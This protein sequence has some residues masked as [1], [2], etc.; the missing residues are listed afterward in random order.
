M[1]RLFAILVCYV[2]LAA[3]LTQ[4]TQM[5]ATFN[6]LARRSRMTDDALRR[7]LARLS[8]AVGG[9]PLVESKGRRLVLTAL[10]HEL[11]LIAQ[12][13]IAVTQGGQ[14]ETE[15]V[16]SLKI[17]VAVGIDPRLLA[18]AAVRFLEVYQEMLALQFETLD[19]QTISEGIR[20]GTVA[21]AVVWEGDQLTPGGKRLEPGLRWSVLTPSS[22]HSLSNSREPVTAKRLAGCRVILPPKALVSPE[23]PR[24]LSQVPP[25][26]QVLADSAHCVRAMVEAGLG[27]GLDLDFGDATTNRKEPFC[28]LPIEGL[29]E[30]H[31]CLYVPRQQTELSEPAGFLFTAFQDAVRD[32]A[33]PP[34]PQLPEPGDDDT[35]PEI[36]PL[37]EPQSA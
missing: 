36:S 23:L 15:T 30:E 27:V 26:R 25:A 14:A 16:E 7:T 5:I 11:Y 29:A 37:P 4:P 18:V 22:G 12:R 1:P 13:L 31:I 32:L 9:D 19:P 24:L 10:G 28:R 2:A 33:L 17:A 35:F 20:S 8:E 6:H 3:P 34:I 21:F